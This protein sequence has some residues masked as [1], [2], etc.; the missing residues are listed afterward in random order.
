VEVGYGAILKEER[1]GDAEVDDKGRR[2]ENREE[3]ETDDGR[4]EE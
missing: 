2:D 1:R 4:K 3:A